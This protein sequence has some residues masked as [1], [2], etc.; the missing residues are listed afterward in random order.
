MNIKR[1]ILLT[2]ILL[3]ILPSLTPYASGTPPKSSKEILIDANA[4]VIHE[5]FKHTIKYT[6]QYI[7]SAESIPVLMYHHILPQKDMTQYGWDN[8]SAVISLEN[9]SEQ[10]K[11]LYDNNYHTATLEEL[12]KFVKGEILL[13]KKTVVITFD[14]GY[15]SNAINAYPI[16]KQY[17]QRGIIFIV[18]KSSEK[19][20]DPYTP[21]NTSKIGI[22]IMNNFTD[23]F[24]Y[25]SHTY[26]MHDMENGKTRI[27]YYTQDQIKEDLL[28]NKAL[29]SNN[30]IAYPHGRYNE[31]VLNVLKELD[32]KL[33]FTI[34]KGY[35]N[36]NTPAF[37]IPRINIGPEISIDKYNQI[38]TNL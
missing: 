17:D 35:T 34:K 15:L 37:E 30:A 31:N 1:T 36:R 26:D 2:L 32:F 21:Q 28:L 20:Q 27:E 23:V 5:A 25:G 13:P 29:F 22:E 3:F 14:D 12:E 10:M 16:M 7:N 24:E 8:N 19:P 6:D 33:G 4:R 38:I 11:Y 18:G 9:F